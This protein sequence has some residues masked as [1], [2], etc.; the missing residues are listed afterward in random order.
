MYSDAQADRG[1]KTFDACCISC[2]QPQAFV[3][4]FLKAW[5]GRTVDG[6]FEAV[7]TGM[8]ED[9][10]GGLK[11]QDYADILAFI[12]KQNGVPAGT[13]ELQSTA[14]ALKQITVDVPDK[15]ADDKA[16]TSGSAPPRF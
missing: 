14:S 8:P 5:N 16:G 3:G 2:H 9:N 4:P 11:G 10:P 15:P 12:F 7:R 6:L 1:G 13:G